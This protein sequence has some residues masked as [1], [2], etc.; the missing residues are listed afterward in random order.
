MSL[1]SLLQLYWVFRFT[2][3]Q[4]RLIGIGGSVKKVPQGLQNL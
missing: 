3:V 2:Y 1:P 4:K